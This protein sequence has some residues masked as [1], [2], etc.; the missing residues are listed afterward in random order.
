VNDIF[1]T[2]LNM[3]ITGAFVIAAVVIARLPLRRAPKWISYC[4][5]LVAAFRLVVPF[6]FESSVSLLPFQAEPVQGVQLDY[7]VS[8]SSAVSGA[9]QSIG[10]ALSQDFHDPVVLYVEPG[11]GDYGANTVQVGPS[12]AWFIFGVYIYLFGIAVMLIYSVITTVILRRKLRFSAPVGGNVFEVDGIR[13]PLVF[14][15]FR[16][17]IYLPAGLVGRERAYILLHEQTHIKRRD[18]LVKIFAFAVLCVHWFNPLAWLAFVLMTADMEMSCDER[19]MRELGGAGQSGFGELENLRHDY[20][21]SLV[22]LAAGR[23][24]IGAS[25]LAF[26]EGGMKERVKRVLNFRKPSR[27]IVLAAVVLVAALSVG[28]AVNRADDNFVHPTIPEVKA[29]SSSS[30]ATALN[31][32]LRWD[33]GVADALAPWQGDY[34]PENTLYTDGDVS[35]TI[36]SDAVESVG[37]SL[38]LPDGTPVEYEIS[39]LVFY[40]PAKAPVY[41]CVIDVQYTKDILRATYGVKLVRNGEEFPTPTTSQDNAVP[42]AQAQAQAVID[43][44]LELLKAKDIPALAQFLVMDG[45]GSTMRGEAER[46]VEYYWNRVGRDYRNNGVMTYDF[47][48]AELAEMNYDAQKRVFICTVLV[49]APADYDE[50]RQCTL[51]IRL[52]YMDSLVGPDIQQSAHWLLPEEI[53]NITSLTLYLPDGREFEPENSAKAIRW[54]EENFGKAQDLGFV[55]ECGYELGVTLQISTA[56]GKRGYVYPATDGCGNFLSGGFSY[57]WGGSNADFYTWFGAGSYTLLH[58][59]YLTGNVIDRYYSSNNYS[60]HF[61]S[62]E[63]ISTPDIPAEDWEDDWDEAVAFWVTIRDKN[64]ETA[65]YRTIVL[66][67]RRSGEWEVFSEMKS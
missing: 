36:A 24:I 61:I 37:V 35:L 30:S 14:G 47:S 66:T 45:D 50:G 2:V 41:I 56:G 60:H 17:K 43:R 40:L 13:T 31:F 67:R 58:G 65:E 62:Y 29:V 28:L 53:K 9:Y 55:G 27:I 19:V 39:G 33:K 15:L 26:G 42:K 1:Q 21:A 18:Y 46:V 25:P 54:V 7:D 22:R 59:A 52:N 4:L 32:G 8:F 12:Q 63:Q 23:R 5:W 11:W 38:L 48:T 51:E 20:S 49:D 34:K 6:S 64:T 10:S 3:S 16:P 57:E 44:Y